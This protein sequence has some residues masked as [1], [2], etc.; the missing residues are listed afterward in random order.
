MLQLIFASSFWG[1]D[2]HGL[3]MHHSAKAYYPPSLHEKARFICEVS[4]SFHKSSGCC[5]TSSE[6]RRVYH[7]DESAFLD[8]FPDGWDLFYFIKNQADTL[9]QTTHNFVLVPHVYNQAVSECHEWV[10]F[11][12]QVNNF[13]GS[14]Y[15][16]TQGYSGD[17]GWNFLG[18]CQAS[19]LRMEMEAHINSFFRNKLAMSEYHQMPLTAINNTTCDHWHLD[20]F[21]DSAIDRLQIPMSKSKFE[22]R[23]PRKVFAPHKSKTKRS[24]QGADSYA[25]NLKAIMEYGGAK[26]VENVYKNFMK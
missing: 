22:F 18:T 14:N 3:K 17:C 11:F 19:I 24:A 16:T 21:M 12:Q 4:N 26:D 20:I 7:F 5:A 6:A 8:Y 9:I 15:E 1:K 10:E 2:L 23:N 13:V 25:G